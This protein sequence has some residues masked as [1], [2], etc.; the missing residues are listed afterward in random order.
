MNRRTFVHRASITAA[1][2]GILRNIEACAPAVVPVAGPPAPTILPGTFAEL[3]DQYFLFHLDKNP[4]TA[5][6]LGGDG[7]SPLLA[8]NLAAIYAQVGRRDQVL[9]L[10][11]RVVSMALLEPAVLASRL[12]KKRGAAPGLTLVL[13]VASGAV[14]RAGV[15][16][17]VFRRAL[18]AALSDLLATKKP[19]KSLS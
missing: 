10:G 18:A 13:P 16:V 5:T 12:D 15:P 3:R 11:P 17:D 8:T 19:P 6:Y 4:V 7:Y 14:V 1:G 2:F 9:G